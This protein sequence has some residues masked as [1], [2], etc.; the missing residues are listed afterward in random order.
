MIY[1]LKKSGKVYVSMKLIPKHPGV[2]FTKIASKWHL[3]KARWI[4]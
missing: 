1:L 4:L 3:L 2:F